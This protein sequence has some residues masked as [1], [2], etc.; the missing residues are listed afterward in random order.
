MG[1]SVSHCLQPSEEERGELYTFNVILRWPRT[2][3][4]Q[5]I[6]IAIRRRDGIRVSTLKAYVKALLRADEEEAPKLKLGQWRCVVEKD[7]CVDIFA[8]M[9]FADPKGDEFRLTCCM[10]PEE[11]NFYVLEDD[12]YLLTPPGRRPL[13]YATLWD[14][15]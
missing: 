10:W 13:I 15:F 2:Q 3:H 1:I 14:D 12:E 9:W 5:S 7:T 8:T 6:P 4:V 11:F